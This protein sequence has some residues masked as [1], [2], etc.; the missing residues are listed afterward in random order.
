MFFA[1][2]RT[3]LE[4]C[5]EW[6]LSEVGPSPRRNRAAGRTSQSMG[7]CQG[8]D[9][10]HLLVA[11]E[12]LHVKGIYPNRNALPFPQTRLRTIVFAFFCSTTH[13]KFSLV[14][15]LQAIFIDTFFAFKKVGR[16]IRKNCSIWGGNCS[17]SHCC[18]WANLGLYSAS[19]DGSTMF[20]FP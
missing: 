13:S 3:K 9:G 14:H 10:E 7:L 20:L 1:T 17:V 6:K 5:H 18:A 12:S 15:P 2:A 4:V 11:S 8:W 16:S 19:E